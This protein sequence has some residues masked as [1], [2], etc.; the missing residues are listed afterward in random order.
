M[1]SAQVEFMMQFDR[2]CEEALGMYERAFG[3]KRILLMRFA[4]AAAKDLP[5]KYDA[6]CDK[7]LIFHAQMEI[8]GRRVMMCDNL[9]NDMPRGH[10]VYPVLTFKTDDEVRAAFGVLSE[11]ATI[12]SPLHSTTYSSC[13]GSLVDKFGI[14][15]DLMVY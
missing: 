13:V 3:A 1:N 2:Q 6:A 8:G 5:P 11:E 7:D 10:S 12:V 14:F 9:F 4:E 15:W